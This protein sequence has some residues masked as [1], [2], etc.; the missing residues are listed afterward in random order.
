[1]LEDANVCSV[2]LFVV[3]L[4]SLAELHS[5]A[6]L[7]RITEAVR[8]AGLESCGKEHSYL[9]IV[10]LI[11]KLAAAN[12]DDVELGWL[13]R[14]MQIMVDAVISNWSINITNLL[15]KDETVGRVST[16]NARD[17]STEGDSL[18]VQH[19][20]SEVEVQPNAPELEVQPHSSEMQVQLHSSGMEF[21]PNA[22]ELE[23]QPN[24]PELEVQLYA[25][26]FEVQPDAP[27]LEV[28]A[29]APELEVQH[30]APELENQPDAPEL[31]D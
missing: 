28:Q 20:S 26:E 22:P 4:K 3:A 17:K 5:E 10:G 25:P 16:E 12:P 23:V 15:A 21:E 1:M 27:E 6:C 2:T 29:N 31:E 8:N 9:D 13:H 30:N 19:H 18:E 7:E 24:A 11:T 14:Y